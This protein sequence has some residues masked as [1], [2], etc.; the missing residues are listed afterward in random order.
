MPA[1][2]QLLVTAIYSI[3]LSPERRRGGLTLHMPKGLPSLSRGCMSRLKCFPP[4]GVWIINENLCMYIDKRL[5]TE[6]LTSSCRL[7]EF[8]TATA[9]RHVGCFEDWGVGSGLYEIFF[10]W[11]VRA[12][13]SYEIK[14]IR[15]ISQALTALSLAWLGM[16][17]LNSNVV[18]P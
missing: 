12:F 10:F 6:I 2:S 1:A 13:V 4:A 18:W 16:T 9:R 8:S 11:S 3:Y 17:G 15:R 5:P 14:C 7:W